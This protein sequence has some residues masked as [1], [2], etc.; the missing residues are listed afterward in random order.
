V[1]ALDQGVVSGLVRSP[2]PKDLPS[3]K[4]MTLNV[5]DNKD[6]AAAGF[7][8]TSLSGSKQENQLIK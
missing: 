4:T 3:D 6:K 8:L 5:K 2:N 1:L 7:Q